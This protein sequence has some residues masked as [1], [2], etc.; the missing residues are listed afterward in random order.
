MKF[1]PRE[2]GF[3]FCEPEPASEQ[4]SEAAKVLVKNI[5][6]E[7]D[8]ATLKTSLS[9]WRALTGFASIFCDSR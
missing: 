3:E 4:N 1:V 2:E 9:Y 6:C 5:G 7:S 8:P